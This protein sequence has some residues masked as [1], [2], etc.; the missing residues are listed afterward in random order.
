MASSP[1]FVSAPNVGLT[2]FVAA[3]GTTIKTIFSPGAS[4][5]RI[6]SLLQH[7]MIRPRC[8]SRSTW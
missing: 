6:F 5:S 1:Q 4:G 7:R 3:D 8:S 2:K